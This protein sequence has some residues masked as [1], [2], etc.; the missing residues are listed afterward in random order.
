MRYC[1]DKGIVVVNLVTL[2][3]GGVDRETERAD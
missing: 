3:K 1:K 2:K